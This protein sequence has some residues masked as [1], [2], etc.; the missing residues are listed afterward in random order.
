MKVSKRLVLSIV[1]AV[2]ALPLVGAVS[3]ASAQNV[4]VNGDFET[5]DLTG[6]D[7]V[8]GNASAQVFVQSPDNG[9]TLPGTHNAYL[10]NFG[11]AIG[12]NLKQSTAV[13]S[14]AEGEV[15]Y[16]F[17]LKLDSANIGGVVFVQMFA[18]QDGVGIVG[19]SGLLGPLWPWNAWTTYTGSFMAP[20]GTDFLTIRIEAATGAAIGADCLVH[21]DNVSM[22]QQGVVAT[23]D[24]SWSGVKALYR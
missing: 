23:E 18:E 14:A 17:D 21:A 9:P 7:V 1:F 19:G 10:E 4:L 6:W 2:L 15:T 11:E 24:A 8:G 22:E 13:G 3:D 16:S 12:L 5:G 20:A